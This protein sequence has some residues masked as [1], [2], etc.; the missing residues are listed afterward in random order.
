MV[1]RGDAGAASYKVGPLGAI[2]KDAGWNGLGKATPLVAN[3]LTTL[4]KY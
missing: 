3:T 4:F 2:P 1:R